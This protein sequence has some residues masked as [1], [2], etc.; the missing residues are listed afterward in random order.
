MTRAGKKQTDIYVDFERLLTPESTKKKSSITGKLWV[1]GSNSDL[2]KE[3]ATIAP[4]AHSWQQEY[5]T[6]NQENAEV[7]SLHTP[8]GPVWVLRPQPVDWE[9]Y[10]NADTLTPSTYARYRD[11][12][13]PICNQFDNLGIGS[14]EI[15]TKGLKDDEKLGLLVGLEMAYYKFQPS[16]D[17]DATLPPKF[18]C[19]GID[20]HLVQESRIIGQSINIARHL[21]NIPPNELYP[22]SFADTV[23][24]LFKDLPN[25]KVEIW[26]ENRIAKENMNLLLAVGN[27]SVNKPR[28]VKIHYSASG[29]KGKPIALVGKGVTFDSGGLDIKDAAN[30]RL[31]KKDMGGAACL[32]GVAYWMA[33]SKFS[34]S[35]DFYLPMAENFVGPESFRPSDVL[36]ARNGMTVEIDNTDAEG[37][38]ILADAMCLAVESEPEMIIDVAT[39]TGIVKAALGKDIGG[40]FATDDKL[41][42]KLLAAG[43]RWGDILWRLPLYKGYED[44]LNTVFAKTNHSSASRYGSGITASLFLMK[45]VDELPWAHLDIMAW[46]DPKGAVR[47][48][49]GNGQSVQCLIGFLKTLAK[50]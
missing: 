28:F 44:Q 10:G 22:A 27:A 21:V 2:K 3:L 7:F 36:T 29:S 32:V 13:G 41:A 17:P 50:N 1:L 26:D 39:L 23:K 48:P 4:D 40:L 18:D 15:Q 9:E 34:R 5:A 24:D 49:G 14:V 37:R 25:A 11:L 47:V 19:V 35:C 8:K 30:M 45:F 20:A 46:S 31:M 38:L 16:D 12:V 43:Q 33:K 6:K 42:Q